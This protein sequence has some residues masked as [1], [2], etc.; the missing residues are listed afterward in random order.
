[1]ST[2]RTEDKCFIQG[3]AYAV[4]FLLRQ[5]SPTLAREI[6]EAAVPQK[7]VPK[8]VPEYDAKPIKAAIRRGW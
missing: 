5:D 2:I 1:M 8:Y 3:V 7:S 4:A 6:W